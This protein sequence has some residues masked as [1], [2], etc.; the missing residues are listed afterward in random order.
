MIRIGSDTDIGM[1][2]NSSDWL[3]MNSYPLL[4]PEIVLKMIDLI[5]A[6]VKVGLVYISYQFISYYFFP[7]ILEIIFP[8]HEK[9]FHFQTKGNTLTV[10]EHHLK[11][12][13]FNC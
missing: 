12:Q 5:L 3:G 8:L 2:R 6:Y 4:S 10:K 13:Y 1:N 9:G 11:R 7:F